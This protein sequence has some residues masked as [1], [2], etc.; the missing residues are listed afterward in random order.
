MDGR[1]LPGARL[2]LVVVTI[3]T[4]PGIVAGPGPLFDRLAGL[5]VI[6][7]EQGR[8]KLAPAGA[9][10]AQV[11]VAQPRV[12]RGLLVARGT[13]RTTAVDRMP[14]AVEDLVPVVALAR[15]TAIG[16]MSDQ[17]PARAV[18]LEAATVVSVIVAVAGDQ[19]VVTMVGLQERN[20]V[21]TG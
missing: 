16:S 13:D 14:A 4:A 3:V 6:H 7:R 9:V 12:A 5:A 21:V 17:T 20:D 1:L 19:G 18:G 11:V 15:V 10:A 2:R 8:P